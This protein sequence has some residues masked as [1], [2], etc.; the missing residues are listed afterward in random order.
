M[1]TRNLK[2][3]IQL[4]YANGCLYRADSPA[5]RDLK[6]EEAQSSPGINYARR[7]QVQEIRKQLQ[8]QENQHIISNEIE[9]P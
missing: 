9:T 5:R 8:P 2:E 6:P 4:A 1:N 7:T 3:T